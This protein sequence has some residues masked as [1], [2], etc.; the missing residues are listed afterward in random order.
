MKPQELLGICIPT[1]NRAKILEKNLNNLINKIK[2][3]EIK[4][5]ISDNASNDGTFEVIKMAKLKYQYIEYHRNDINLGMDKNFECALNLCEEKY[6][7]LLGDDD[8][9]GE[10]IEEVFSMLQDNPDV[11]VLGNDKDI[12]EKIY[13]NP[14]EIFEKLIFQTTWISGL[15]ISKKVIKCLNFEKYIGTNFSHTGAIFEHILST[16]LTTVKYCINLNYVGDMRPKFV[17]YS[18]RIL[19]I[20]A[21][22][23]SELIYKLPNLSDEERKKSFKDRTAKSGMLNNKILMSLRAQGLF[24]RQLLREYEKYIKLYNVSPHFV[25]VCISYFPTG[26]CVLARKMYKKMRLS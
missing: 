14:K 9:L 15:I 23:W 20:Y 13:A 18:N 4:I 11:L 10:G 26:I 6:G 12:I 5:Y 16:T 2:D 8:T 21:Q 3:S 24:N 25:L 19:E 17:G 1:Y 22:G 7:W